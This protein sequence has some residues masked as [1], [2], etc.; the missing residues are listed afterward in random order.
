MT[1]G[2]ANYCK[3]LSTDVYVMSLGTFLKAHNSFNFTN[4]LYID[5]DKLSMSVT[6]S[7]NCIYSRNLSVVTRLFN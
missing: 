2:N 1:S 3:S 4:C 5:T 7:Q 6:N